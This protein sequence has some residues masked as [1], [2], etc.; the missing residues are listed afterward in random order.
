[1]NDF[2]K[3]ILKYKKYKPATNEKIKNQ[4]TENFDRYIFSE[5]L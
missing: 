5:I 4:R 1:V 3:K 2:G